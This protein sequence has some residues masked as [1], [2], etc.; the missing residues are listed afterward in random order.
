[1]NEE[2]EPRKTTRVIVFVATLIAG[3]ALFI[4]NIETI[5]NYFYPDRKVCETNENAIVV[6]MKNL[7]TFNPVFFEQK[8]I[9]DVQVLLKAYFENKSCKSQNLDESITEI[10]DQLNRMVGELLAS[11]RSDPSTENE[12]KLNKCL[13]ILNLICSQQN[14]S[15]AEQEK[16][17]ELIKIIQ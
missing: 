13:E 17:N 9:D 2:K 10:K 11:I 16:I 1:M 12:A 5:E 7:K 8:T 4:Q 15:D 6:A 14:C 3:I